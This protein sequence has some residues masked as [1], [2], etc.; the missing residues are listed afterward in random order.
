MQTHSIKFGNELFTLTACT[1]GNDVDVVLNNTLR[2]KFVLSRLLSGS[3]DERGNGVFERNVSLTYRTGNYVYTFICEQRLGQ[4]ESPMLYLVQVM[5]TINRAR[6][7]AGLKP[8]EY[9]HVCDERKVYLGGLLVTSTSLGDLK[10]NDCFVGGL[11]M[12]DAGIHM[13][14]V[15]AKCTS[16]SGTVAY[17]VELLGHI[18][19]VRTSQNMKPFAWVVE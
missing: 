6:E 13:N 9:T 18:N 5:A 10:I 11:L 7:S 12:L 16:K 8:I 15:K 19:K 2:T 4:L 1:S 17:T 14:N 3:V